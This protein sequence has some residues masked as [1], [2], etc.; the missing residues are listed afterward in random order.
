MSLF[1]AV[2]TILAVL[3][4]IYIPAAFRVRALRALAAR[5]GLRYMKK[6][7]PEAFAIDRRKFLYHWMV[8]PK[9]VTH[10]IAGDCRGRQ[11]VIFDSM[12]PGK[13]NMRC[14]VL[15]IQTENNPFEAEAD[16]WKVVQSKGWFAL[17]R[18][19]FLQVPWTMSI[20]EIEDRLGQIWQE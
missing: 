19:G 15:A 2:L 6:K 7:L 12:A 3:A 4:V 20:G 10:V 16:P 5:W 8:D 1:A 18:T 17:W 13:G 11:V 9:T 14:T